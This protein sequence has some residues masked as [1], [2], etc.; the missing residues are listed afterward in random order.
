MRTRISDLNMGPLDA[1]LAESPARCF[2]LKSFGDELT[3]TVWHA[4]SACGTATG[5]AATFSELL[6]SAIAGCDRRQV[7]AEEEQAIREEARRRIAEREALESASSTE[8]AATDSERDARGA[9][10]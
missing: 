4:A 7:E 5:P 10:E 8:R 3:I 6:A 9:A 1:W 2:K